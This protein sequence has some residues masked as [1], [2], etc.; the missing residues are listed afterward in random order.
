[1]RKDYEEILLHH[2]YAI[3]EPDVDVVYVGKTT[4]EN[5]HKKRNDAINGRILSVDGEFSENCKFSLLESIY[6]SKPVAFRHILA[7]YRFFEENGYDVLAMNGA[8]YMLEFPQN[9][10]M[11]IYNEVCL[12]H[13]VEEVLERK[14]LPLKKIEEPEQHQTEQCPFTQLNIRVRENVADSFRSLSRKLGLSQNDTLKLLMTEK[15]DEMKISLADEICVLKQE[16]HN[17]KELL[18]RQRKQYSKDKNRSI[19][20]NR[21]LVKIFKDSINLLADFLKGLDFP[22]GEIIKPKRFNACKELFHSYLYPLTSGCCIAT[23]DEIIMGKYHT[24]ELGKVTPTKF[25]LFS[26]LDGKKIKLRLYEKN[27]FAGIYPMAHA[28]INSLWI[29]GYT[30]SDDGAANM[31]LG[32]PIDYVYKESHVDEN[33][34][35][36]KQNYSSLDDLISSAND[37]I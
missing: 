3:I 30:I 28:Y 6:V 14:V 37:V 35:F 1:M 25:L 12:P 17:Y 20:K 31:V 24:S 19:E 16:I 15:N 8:A 18:E 13:S 9:E 33:I 4:I 5:P 36:E 27:S 29:V 10:T 11:N 23:M 22:A 26:T 34:F 21:Q 7:W 2:I 32:I